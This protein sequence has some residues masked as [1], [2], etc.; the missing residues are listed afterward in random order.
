MVCLSLA[1]LPSHATPTHRPGILSLGPDALP[2]Q[3]SQGSSP[4]FQAVDDGKCSCHG[5]NKKLTRFRSRG[6]H[7][8]FSIDRGKSE[9]LSCSSK[10]V[11]RARLPLSAAFYHIAAAQGYPSSSWR[12]TWRRITSVFVQYSFR[13]GVCG[14]L[15]L[16]A[17][18]SLT[19]TAGSC[20]TFPI[21]RRSVA[22]GKH[23]ATTL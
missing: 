9:G 2:R 14:Q 10:S 17:T 7:G 5:K 16:G 18:M 19:Q 12:S 20:P 22:R 13:T 6:L 21:S 8:C 11:A 23:H 3:P 4:I 1:L 15:P